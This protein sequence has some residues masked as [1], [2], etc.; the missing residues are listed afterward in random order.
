MTPPLNPGIAVVEHV[1]P[2]ADQFFRPFER[3]FTAVIVCAIS[4]NHE[5][6]RKTL[7]LVKE[8]RL[9]VLPISGAGYYW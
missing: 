9:A 8:F 2:E 1:G 3:C 4:K 5:P 6:S 7:Q